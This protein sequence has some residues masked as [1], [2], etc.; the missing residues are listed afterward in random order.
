MR[1][2]IQLVSRRSSLNCLRRQFLMIIDGF[3]VRTHFNFLLFHF[4]VYTYTDVKQFLGTSTSHRGLLSFET[5]QTLQWTVVWR[6]IDYRAD[7]SR[8]WIENEFYFL[9][10]CN[11]HNFT[12]DGNV[13]CTTEKEHFEAMIEHDKNC[14]SLVPTQR[15]W[16]HFVHS[17]FY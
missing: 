13:I 9:I 17:G 10:V 12:E 1:T 11:W 15:R 6:L 4:H 14:W 5:N 16:W 8:F 7:S 2:K 3:L